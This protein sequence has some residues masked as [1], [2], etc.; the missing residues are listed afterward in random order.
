LTLN[1]K[2]EPAIF[3]TGISDPSALVAGSRD[4]P[5]SGLFN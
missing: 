1:L 2:D 5:F 3:F 4:P